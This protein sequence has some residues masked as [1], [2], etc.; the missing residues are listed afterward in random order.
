[1]TPEVRIPAREI[2]HTVLRCS[3]GKNL[4]VSQKTEKTIVVASEA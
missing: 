2:R 1:M 3:E 4:P